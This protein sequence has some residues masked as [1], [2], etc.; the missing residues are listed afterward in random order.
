MAWS[1]PCSTAGHIQVHA[2]EVCLFSTFERHDW[3]FRMLLSGCQ[4]DR[5][6]HTTCEV[7]AVQ[8]AARAVH[9]T[10]VR[11]TAGSYHFFEDVAR[12]MTILITAQ[13]Q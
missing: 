5:A 1:Q 12:M 4:Q 7:A 2:W 13:L 3:C 6:F 8:S 11:P 10:A 9:A